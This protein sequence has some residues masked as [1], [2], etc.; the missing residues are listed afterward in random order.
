[1]S[2]NE[3]IIDQSNIST[4]ENLEIANK[5]KIKDKFIKKAIDKHNDKYNY[6]QVEYIDSKTKVKIFC[7]KCQDFYFQTPSGHLKGGCRRCSALKNLNIKIKT[8]DEFLEKAKKTH[9]NKYNYDQIEYV[10]TKTKLSIFCK[11]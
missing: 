9:G 6:D 5:K 11:K 4:K 3:E 8:K 10:N 2:N 1:M 7:N